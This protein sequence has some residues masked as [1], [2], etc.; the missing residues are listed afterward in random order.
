MKERSRTSS[1]RD[2]ILFHDSKWSWAIYAVVAEIGF[3]LL[4]VSFAPLYRSKLI[5]EVCWILH[6]P[7]LLALDPI[8]TRFPKDDWKPECVFI[9][10][11]L[12]Y[13]A[14]VGF[15]LGSVRDLVKSRH[16]A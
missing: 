8:L 14:A 11:F 9:A 15:L 13:A 2:R 7:L 5:S 10:M 3:W 16:R 1:I 12:S 6:R 4:F